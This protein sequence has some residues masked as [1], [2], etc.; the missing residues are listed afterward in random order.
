MTGT[1]AQLPLKPTPAPCEKAPS[2]PRNFLKG[3]KQLTI[4]PS[5]EESDEKTKI[6]GKISQI[7]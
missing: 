5:P 6:H 1:G 7:D 4:T 2:T 3:D